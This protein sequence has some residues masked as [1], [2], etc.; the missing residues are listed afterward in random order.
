MSTKDSL[1]DRMKL[2]ESAFNHTYPIRMPLII[3]FDG[4]HFHSN[5]K[6]WK[7]KK[8]FDDNLIDAM[9]FT[10]KALCEA[11]SGAQIAYVQS[12]E[13]TI[14]IRDD[15]S[16]KSQP[17]YN[18]EIN[19]I[20]SVGAAKATNAFNFRYQQLNGSFTQMSQMAEFDARGMVFPEHEIFS[21]FHWRQTDASRNSI[22][23]LGHA[24][25]SQKELHKKSC[26]EIQ[27][28]LFQQHN[29]NWNNIPTHYKR[30]ACVIKVESPIEV[31]KRNE[32]GKII[33]YDTEIIMRSK[34][35]IDNEIPI[36]TQ[37]RDYIN[38]FAKLAT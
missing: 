5:V 22:Q 27:E 29:I 10:A 28:M 16:N 18:K 4:V 8:P 9:Q 1:G 13:I 2:Y 38:K 20:L 17:W 21:E 32:L 15:M 23:M 36:F 14:L 12:D 7:C 33:E 3:R 30:G 35:V 37:D 26:D 25:F 19:K 11:I 6:R 31:P 24:N 34:W